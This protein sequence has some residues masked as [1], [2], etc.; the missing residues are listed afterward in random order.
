ML[1]ATYK[2]NSTKPRAARPIVA[3]TLLV[4]ATWMLQGCTFALHVTPDEDP[5]SVSQQHSTQPAIAQTPPPP[6]EQAAPAA[7]PAATVPADDVV[8]TPKE[9]PSDTQA[10]R[11]SSRRLDVVLAFGQ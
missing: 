4:A 8:A 7:T 9:L 5:S 1:Q 6:I 2:N 10:R 11:R 3:A